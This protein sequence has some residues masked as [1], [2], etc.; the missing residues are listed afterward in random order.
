MSTAN[1]KV[2][3][4]IRRHRSIRLR[5]HGS[6]TRPRIAV[7]RSARHIYAQ[8]IDDT[9]GRTLAC[10]STLDSELDAGDEGKIETARRVG[11]LLAQRA[12]AL[13]IRQAVFDRGGFVY[14]G[15]VAALAEGARSGGLEF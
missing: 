15:R 1:D 7:F 12:S 6:P 11:A 8:L 14:H 10:A 13:E 3:A 2:Q 4:R 9:T 5:V